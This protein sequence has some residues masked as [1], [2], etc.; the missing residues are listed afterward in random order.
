MAQ[1]RAGDLRQRLTI[2]RVNEVPN[3]KG[4]FTED[5]GD[6]ATI[7][8]QVIGLDGPTPRPASRET[9]VNQSLEAIAVYQVRIRWR[10]DVYASDQLRPKGSCFGFDDNGK[11]RDVNIRSINDP[12]GRREQLVIVADTSSRRS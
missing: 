10:P 2:R 8:A 4:G 3:G 9:V 12:D 6:V 7:F 1:L 5:W 11:K